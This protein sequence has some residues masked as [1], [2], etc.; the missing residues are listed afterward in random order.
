MTT[1]LLTTTDPKDLEKALA[2]FLR[3]NSGSATNFGRRFL[4]LGVGTPTTYV[5]GVLSGRSPPKILSSLT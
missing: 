5:G 4:W 2:W 1:S 3:P